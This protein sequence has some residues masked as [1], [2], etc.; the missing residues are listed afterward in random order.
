MLIVG[1]SAGL[2][3]GVGWGAV[4]AVVVDAG[5]V[6]DP[7][8]AASAGF[9]DEGDQG[10]DGGSEE[11]A[12]AEHDIKPVVDVDLEA[13]QDG[14]EVGGDL[15]AFAGLEDASGVVDEFEVVV[16]VDA[17]V[18]GGEGGGDPELVFG[19]VGLGLVGAGD[20]FGRD[21]GGAGGGAFAFGLGDEG[22]GLVVDLPSVNAA[23]DAGVV[24][25]LGRGRHL[26]ADRVQIDVGHAADDGGVIE[27]GDALESTFPE[28][29][30]HAV[31]AVG[32]S[33]DALLEDPHEPA[34]RSQTLAAGFDPGGIENLHSHLPCD[35]PRSVNPFSSSAVSSK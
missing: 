26:G 25:G 3:R 1:N 8:E 28:V 33:G 29:T 18:G 2:G 14:L 6:G 11:L 32:A 34:D 27:Q 4:A 16:E 20:Q 31:L 19:A 12:V 30:G 15:A 5:F 7:L 23:L 9:G 35:S 24:A 17:V 10:A 21:G 22:A 13:F